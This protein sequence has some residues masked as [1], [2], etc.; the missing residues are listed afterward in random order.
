MKKGGK[1]KSV[2]RK[3][4]DKMERRRK[5][6][7]DWRIQAFIAAQKMQSGNRAARK[8]FMEAAFLKEH[9][10]EFT[11][12]REKGEAKTFHS[13]VLTRGVYST[14]DRLLCILKDPKASFILGQRECR[15]SFPRGKELCIVFQ[16]VRF[17]LTRNRCAHTCGK[18]T[19]T[20]THTNEIVQL[21]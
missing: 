6:Q 19:D 21:N 14:S 9:N 3:G 7:P 17:I 11:L 13:L 5:R 2:E 16:L 18:K 8:S 20:H 1:K 15:P 12:S 10:A 4:S